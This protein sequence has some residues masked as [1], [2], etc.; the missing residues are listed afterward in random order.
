MLYMPTTT[1]TSRPRMHRAVALAWLVACTAGLANAQVADAPA[2]TTTASEE[3]ALAAL[4]GD[5][6]ETAAPA[7]F[8][9]SLSLYGWS[10]FGA[11]RAWGGLNTT[12]L[13]GTDGMTFVTR[14]NLY[15][16]AYPAPDARVLTEL[17]FGLFPDGALDD[18]QKLIRTSASDLGS[19]YG[20]F[21]RLKWSGIVLERAQA[22]WTPRDDFNVRAGLFLTPYGIWNVDHGAP[23]RITLTAPLFITLGLLPERQ[24]GLE[25]FG[26]FAPLPW[27]IGYHL[28]VGNGRTWGSNDPTDDKAFGG[29]IFARTRQPIAFTLGASAYTGTYHRIDTAIT[30]RPD[31]IDRVETTK[32]AMAEHA[33]AFDVSADVGALR[34]RSEV[35]L[36]WVIYEDGKREVAGPGVFSSDA[37]H[38]GAYLMAAYQ[39]PWW[40]LEPLAMIEWVRFPNIIAEDAVLPSV[41][42][43]IYFAPTMTLRVQ[44]TY[45]HLY[46]STGPERD[47]PQG[48]N[49][50]F[51]ARFIA[52]Y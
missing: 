1:N 30:L 12:G 2:E 3:E 16:D 34:L 38:V 26:T 18:D 19:P 9:P 35:L 25:V 48:Y 45:A 39:L 22:D 24:L 13:V 4:I 5:A 8:E 14:T 20:G 29:R 42:L 41:G 7:A 11:Q 36:R 28:Y 50:F 51:A 43:N 46:D 27:T 15:I 17:R 44:Y 31:G 23:T 52:S 6:E 49:H 47:L 10:E 32:I 37:M 21:G 40:S 33:L